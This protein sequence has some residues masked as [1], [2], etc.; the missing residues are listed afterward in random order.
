MSPASPLGEDHEQSEDDRGDRCSAG[1]D[2]TDGENLTAQGGEHRPPA[3]DQ[4]AQAGTGPGLRAE[5][6]RHLLVS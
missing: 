3:V 6:P 1:R 2:A 5:K 4:L